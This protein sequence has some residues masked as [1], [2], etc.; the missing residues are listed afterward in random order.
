MSVNGQTTI[1]DLLGQ[2]PQAVGVL[3]RYGMCESCRLDPP[4]VPLHQFAEKHCG[5]DV[6]AL[7]D[8]LRVVGARSTDGVGNACD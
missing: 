3:L 2:Y 8:E 5:G 6:E 1:R 4:P 7:L